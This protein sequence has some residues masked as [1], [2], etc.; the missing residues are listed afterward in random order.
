VWG[1]LPSAAERIEEGALHDARSALQALSACSA[2]FRV[3][4]MVELKFASAPRASARLC[5]SFAKGI[6]IFGKV[7]LIAGPRPET[8][9]ELDRAK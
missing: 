2:S 4:G 8:S 3:R 9:P 1:G 6:A 5:A 7:Q